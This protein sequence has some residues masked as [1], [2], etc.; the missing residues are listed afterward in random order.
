M[1][2]DQIRKRIDEK[3]SHFTFLYNGVSCGVDPYSDKEYDIWYGDKIIT[4]DSIEEVM[5]NPFFGGKSLTAIS[6][7]I[8]IQD[9]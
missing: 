3:A 1:T 8:Q 6:R 2:N 4:V 7:N 9:F 5:N